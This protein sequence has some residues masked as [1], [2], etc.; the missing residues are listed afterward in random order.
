VGGFFL[1]IQGKGK[2]PELKTGGGDNPPFFAGLKKK[3]ES[4]KGASKKTGKNEIG[5][6]TP[7]RGEMGE[8][9]GPTQ[10]PFLK[11]YEKD[12]FEKWLLAQ[13]RGES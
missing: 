12:F 13:G 5:G 7:H 4:G 2:E 8:K 1:K 9:R 10:S 3:G 6:K 11:T